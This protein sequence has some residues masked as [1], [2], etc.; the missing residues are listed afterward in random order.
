[1]NTLKKVVAFIRQ[2]NQG[3][4]IGKDHFSIADNLRAKFYIIC[5]KTSI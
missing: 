5:L 2:A 4:T 3:Q 1:M